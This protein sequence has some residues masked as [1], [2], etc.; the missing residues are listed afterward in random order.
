MKAVARSRAMVFTGAGGPH[1]MNGRRDNKTQG[2]QKK[3]KDKKQQ[4]KRKIPGA[5]G[6]HPA[7][8]TH[9]KEGEVGRRQQMIL[10]HHFGPGFWAAAGRD[11]GV[12]T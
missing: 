9:F 2:K 8:G 1:R 6:D 11:K 4:K 3:K 12:A 5:I 10:P 7:Q